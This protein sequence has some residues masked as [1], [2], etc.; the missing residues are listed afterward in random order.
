MAGKWGLTP[1]KPWWR[2]DRICSFFTRKVTTRHPMI[3]ECA[4]HPG[5]Q[6]HVAHHYRIFFIM[7]AQHRWE[8]SRKVLR[9]SS[10]CSAVRT[11]RFGVHELEVSRAGYVFQQVGKVC[12]CT[13]TPSDRQKRSSLISNLLS[14]FDCSWWSAHVTTLQRK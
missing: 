9:V 10:L 8:G 7:L 11:R 12:R 2:S 6:L 14:I 3:I 13:H 5:L 4:E 1:D